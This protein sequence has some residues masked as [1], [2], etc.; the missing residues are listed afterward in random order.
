MVHK[1]FYVNMSVVSKYYS[2]YQ[3]PHTQ[4]KYS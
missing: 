2:A 4:M 3:F 1:Y